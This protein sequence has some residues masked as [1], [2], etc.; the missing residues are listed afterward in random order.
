[1]CVCKPVCI[2]KA[3]QILYFLLTCTHTSSFLQGHCCHDVREQNQN[4]NCIS[5]HDRKCHAPH[6]LLLA[7]GWHDITHLAQD[8]TLL[9][10]TPKLTSLLRQS[11]ACADASSYVCV[12]AM[13]RSAIS[14]LIPT[15]LLAR[16][17]LFFCS[18]ISQR[19]LQQKSSNKAASAV[20]EPAGVTFR[21]K[22]HD[23]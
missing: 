14:P 1:M 17:H 8:M 16:G 19:R 4:S 5:G 21:C 18:C 15:S 2:F 3:L 13:H 23:T 10:S 11:N 6:L 7:H 12:Q 20:Q 22:I 9:R